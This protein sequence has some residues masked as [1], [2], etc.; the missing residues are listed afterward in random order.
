M[1]ANV[2]AKVCLHYSHRKHTL[3]E[4]WMG[5]GEEEAEEASRSPKTKSSININMHAVGIRVHIWYTIVVR[6]YNTQIPKHEYYTLHISV[7]Y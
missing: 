5:G 4:L 1:Y 3:V 6:I 7:E 2:F